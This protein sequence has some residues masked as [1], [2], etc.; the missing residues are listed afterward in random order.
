MH[1]EGWQEPLEQKHM[2]QNSQSLRLSLW[3]A[4]IKKQENSMGGQPMAKKESTRPRPHLIF[5]GRNSWNK[6][7]AP[8]NHWIQL[9]RSNYQQILF[10]YTLLPVHSSSRTL[11]N[12]ET[13]TNVVIKDIGK[14]KTN[15]NNN[16]HSAIPQVGYREILCPQTLPTGTQK[17]KGG[18]LTCDHSNPPE[19]LH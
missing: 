13:Q 19:G 7:E 8:I 2:P 1:P 14:Q 16:I 17:Q 4:K 9:P 10:K 12:I 18:K 3:K 15:N 5:V 6:S 11:S